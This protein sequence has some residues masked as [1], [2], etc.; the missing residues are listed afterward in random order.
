MSIL[1]LDV[2]TIP[3]GADIHEQDPIRE[4]TGDG[5]PCAYASLCPA[6]CEIAC[7]GLLALE[8]TTDTATHRQK[9]LVPAAL[10]PDTSGTATIDTFD[11][12]GGM[13]ERL[14]AILSKT[15]TLVTFNGRGFDLPVLALAYARAGMKLP[16]LIEA[17]L[18]Q[19]PWDNRPHIDTMWVLS[20][21]G[22]G[23]R[24]PL[25]AYALG[26]LGSDPKAGGGGASVFDMVLAG[27]GDALA[28][29]CLG[30]CVTTAALLNFAAN[31]AL[32]GA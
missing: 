21:K 1:V 14:A 6:L 3:L 32:P 10:F 18:E 13:L 30:D 11:T 5:D 25:R 8:S 23:R 17:S 20:C 7:V 2:E 24:Y 9:A 15:K 4:L 31:A 22:A 26:L 28:T 16:G 19:K 29:Y 12:C 27:D